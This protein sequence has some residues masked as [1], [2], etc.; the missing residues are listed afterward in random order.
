MC[1]GNTAQF[2]N[3]GRHCWHPK[4]RAGL[5]P[6]ERGR[7]KH[8][9]AIFCG[10]SIG[11]SRFLSR[12]GIGTSH[13]RH[14][15]RR[16]HRCGGFGRGGGVRS[17]EERGAPSQFHGHHTWRGVNTQSIGFRPANMSCRRSAESIKALRRALSRWRPAR[18][19]PSICRSRWSARR[20]CRRRGLDARPASAARRPRRPSAA[21]SSLGRR[22][23]KG[24]H[25]SEMH[26]LP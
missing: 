13:S 3:K 11:C 14:L 23:G 10:S 22:R 26:D 20:R 1:R 19:R 24:H 4:I 21:R 25:R 17:D 18:R 6:S 12:C 16:H 8:V 9:E 15:D 2:Q 5:I 7:F